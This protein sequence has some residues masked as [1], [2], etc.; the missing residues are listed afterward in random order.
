M[1]YPRITTAHQKILCSFE[2]KV[3]NS[4][5]PPSGLSP[6]VESW[7]AWGRGQTFN[8]TSAPLAADSFQ[9]PSATSTSE[10]QGWLISF[11]LLLNSPCKTFLSLHSLP[12]FIF[13]IKFCN[14][15]EHNHSL[16]FFVIESYFWKSLLPVSIVVLYF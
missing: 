16:T 5:S 8:R 13:A 14:R 3:L 10:N 4:Q 1:W 9:T 11:I 15:R 6:P 12:S 2:W 7:E